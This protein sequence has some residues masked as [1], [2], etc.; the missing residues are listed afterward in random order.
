MALCPQFRRAI[1]Y[2]LTRS[3]K[4]HVADPGMA[5]RLLGLDAVHLSL[6][7]TAVGQLFETL[8]AS[9]LLSHLDAGTLATCRLAQRRAPGR[10]EESVVGSSAMTLLT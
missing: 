4:V 7:A 3:P 5:A 6:D 2:R 10:H 8:V 1:L 9:E